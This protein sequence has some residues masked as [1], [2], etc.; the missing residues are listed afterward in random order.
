V[1][2]SPYDPP[3][4]LAT[5]PIHVIAD[6]V[7][8]ATDRRCSRSAREPADVALANREDI[9]ADVAMLLVTTDSRY[10]P[11]EEARATVVE[12]GGGRQRTNS[13]SDVG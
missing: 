7:T 6:D 3:I 2:I 13:Y 11:A 12:A 4:G 9:P 5:Q 1:P 10:L 8:G